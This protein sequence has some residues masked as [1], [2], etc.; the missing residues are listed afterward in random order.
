MVREAGEVAAV[1]FGGDGFGG[2]AFF[3]VV[4]GERFGV[5]GCD[6]VVACV[7]EVEGGDVRGGVG[8]FGGCA[9]ELCVLRWLLVG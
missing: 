6:E 1:F 9:E 7:V 3:D 2:F 5:A 8:G 4:E